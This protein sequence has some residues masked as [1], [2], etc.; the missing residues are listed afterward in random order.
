[1][2]SISSGDESKDLFAGRPPQPIKCEWL[3]ARDKRLAPSAEIIRLV[4]DEGRASCDGWANDVY[5]RH[6][7]R[8]IQEFI[9][10]TN[11]VLMTDAGSI[12]AYLPPMRPTVD[13][14]KSGLLALGTA[15]SHIEPGPMEMLVGV[16]GCV[17]GQIPHLQTIVHVH[18]RIEPSLESTTVKLYPIEDEKPSLIGWKICEELCRVPEKLSPAR[19]VQTGV[20]LVLVLVCNDAAIFGAR[21]RANLKLELKKAIRTHFLQQSVEEP[22]PAYILIATHWQAGASGGNAFRQAADY[23]CAETGSTAVIT[24]RAPR[25]ELRAAAHHFE[26]EGPRKEKVATLLVRD[27]A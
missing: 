4:V 19:R 22:R 5:Q 12:K 16:D 18:G 17:R 2:G 21:S 11:A 24:M 10:P 8:D 1:M 27:T 26:V 23:L 6:F 9:G 15:L 13:S 25:A 7:L 3:T 20:G 14:L